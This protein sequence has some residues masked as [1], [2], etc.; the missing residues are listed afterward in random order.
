MKEILEPQDLINAHNDMVGCL[1]LCA[2]ILTTG[3]LL[4]HFCRAKNN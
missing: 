2:I 4:A 3:L 1:L